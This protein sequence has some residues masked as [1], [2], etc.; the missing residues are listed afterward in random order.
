MVND[1]SKRLRLKEIGDSSGR[2]NSVPPILNNVPSQVA[3]HILVTPVRLPI[4]E[5]IAV[6]ETHSQTPNTCSSTHYRMNT[7]MAI[8][9]A[10]L[11]C[12]TVT[13][14][15]STP[16][17]ICCLQVLHCGTCSLRGE[18]T[19]PLEMVHNSNVQT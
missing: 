7:T 19:P 1:C 2:Q 6:P 17:H 5:L 16:K 14:C 10:Q 13:P 3:S 4:L 11:Y 8:L 12:I 15:L 9:I 18:G